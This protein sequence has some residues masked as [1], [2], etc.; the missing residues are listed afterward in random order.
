LRKIRCIF[1]NFG[2][3]KVIDSR[4]SEDLIRRRREC[5]ECEKRFTTYERAESPN[6]YVAKKDGRRELFDREK[7]KKGMLKACEKRPVEIEK[8][9]NAINKIESRLR[10]LSD[11]EINSNVL[12][13]EVMKHL[14]NIDKIAYIRFASVY[15]EF[16]DLGDFKKEIALLKNEER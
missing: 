10:S 14:M 12:G 15:R 5:I 13:E 8:I 11:N 7:L 3:T 2:E 1:C 6:I 4:E 16:A 9:E